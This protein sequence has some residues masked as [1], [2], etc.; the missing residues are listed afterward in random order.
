MIASLEQGKALI[1]QYIDANET[2][3]AVTMLCRLAVACAKKAKFPQAEAY[4]DLLYEVDC[5]AL[6]AIMKVNE[7]IENEK[8]KRKRPN[9]RRLWPLFTKNLPAEETDDFL[10]ALQALE[11]GD[12]TRVLEQGRPNDCLYLINHGRLKVVFENK[13]REVLI[14]HLTRGQFFGEDTFFSVNVCTASVV[15]MS[16]VYLSYL[17]HRHLVGLQKKHP[18]FEHRLQELCSSGNRT[19]DYLRK[20]NFDRRATRRIHL[21]SKI[22]VQLLTAET[23]RPMQCTE[24]AELWDVSQNGL[25]FYMT[26]KS[27][28]AVQRLIGRTLGVRIKLDVENMPK[29]A[30]VTGEV[31]GVQQHPM[32]Q[33]SVHMKLNPPFSDA[34]M[35][36]IKKI[37]AQ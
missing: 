16:P 30:A 1:H 25:C 23:Q 26:S 7:Y 17:D 9:V 29:L 13:D 24:A 3:R 5:T 18:D 27:R 37:A 33:Y 36:T 34:A 10:L 4:R 20:L 32:D 12:D 14:R 2:D 8:R 6:V 15:T 28:E 11:M 21:R 35:E 19:Y 22:L 31:Q